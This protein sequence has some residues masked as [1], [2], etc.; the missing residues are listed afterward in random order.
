MKFQHLLVVLLLA[1]AATCNVIEL[2][3]G[4]FKNVTQIKFKG[5]CPHHPPTHKHIWLV[6]FHESCGHC[7]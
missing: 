1:A 4:N 5:C 6:M 3:N 2:T 7:K